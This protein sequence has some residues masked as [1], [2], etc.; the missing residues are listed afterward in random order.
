MTG[1][2]LRVL[3]LKREEEWLPGDTWRGLRGKLHEE[4]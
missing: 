3:V 4:Q 1:K 2:E